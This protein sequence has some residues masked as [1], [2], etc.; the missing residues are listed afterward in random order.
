MKEIALILYNK[1]EAVLKVPLTFLKLHW[2]E[3]VYQ[4]MMA[5]YRRKMSMHKSIGLVMKVTTLNTSY[6]RIGILVRFNITSLAIPL[7]RDVGFFKKLFQIY[8]Q[9]FLSSLW[10]HIKIHSPSVKIVSS[11]L[12]K[13]NYLSLEN[14]DSATTMNVG[15]HK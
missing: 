5:L 12:Y 8:H 1:Y 11:T 4:I 9:M 14:K 6:W 3:L 10:V 15:C 7:L 13:T 2:S